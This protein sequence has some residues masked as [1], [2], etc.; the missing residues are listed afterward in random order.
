MIGIAA[1]LTLYGLLLGSLYALA[2]IG[3]T[4]IFGIMGVVNLS[5]GCLLAT[6]AFITYS[7]HKWLGYNVAAAIL[8]SIIILFII[9]VI[10]ERGAVYPFRAAEMTVIILTFL[11]GK[12]LEQ[13]L[14]L[15]WGA[16]YIA[17]PMRI[18]GSF[19][20]F[21][22]I[23]PVYQVVILALSVA[24]ISALWFLLQKTK[25]GRAVRAVAQD[26]EA[27]SIYGVNIS[28]VRILTFALASALAAIAGIL[29]NSVYMFHM[30][31]G[32]EYL[33]IALS[34]TIVGGLGDVRGAIAASLVMG[35]AESFIGY[36]ISPLWRTTVYFVLIIVILVIKPSG[37]A[38]L[39]RG[40]R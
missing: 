35:V 17:S 23:V 12:A 15:I 37:L 39:F 36:L 29:L 6:A 20:I 9:G 33:L 10:I 31:S 38:G 1:Q 14:Y 22:T 27:A 2:A 28:L 11:I 40:G 34:I 13:A 3:L 18:P 8:A 26:E 16:I 7:L 32:W 19:D 5:H 21:G 24:L 25:F 30:T 4:L